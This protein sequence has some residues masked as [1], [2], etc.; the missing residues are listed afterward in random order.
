MRSVVKKNDKLYDAVVG[1]KDSP[2]IM[3]TFT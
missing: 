1:G 3:K 2:D